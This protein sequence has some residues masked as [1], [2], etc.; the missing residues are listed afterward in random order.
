MRAITIVVSILF[1]IGV[2]IAQEKKPVQK[3]PAAQMQK[4]EKNTVVL[5]TLRDKL[6]YVVGY[7]V[8]LKMIGDIQEK[9]L[10]LDSKIFLMAI[11]DAVEGKKPVLSDMDAKGVVDLFQQLLKMTPEDREKLQRQLFSGK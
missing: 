5:K 11:N 10:D 8:A 2:G 6:S 4:P 7:D 1:V 3:K 9:K